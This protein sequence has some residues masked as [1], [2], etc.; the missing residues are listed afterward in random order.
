MNNS[1]GFPLFTMISHAF[2][3]LICD[4][5]VRCWC[6]LR[7]ASG[8]ALPVVESQTQSLVLLED[9]PCL[10]HPCALERPWHG[11]AMVCGVFL[12]LPPL[13]SLDSSTI[14]TIHVVFQLPSIPGIVGILPKTNAFSGIERHGHQPMEPLLSP[15]TAQPFGCAPWQAVGRPL[16]AVLI[17]TVGFR[18]HHEGCR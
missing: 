18:S 5:Y 16:A 1:I 12:V 9:E 8:V 2:I 10:P 11:G 3:D 6:V 14:P 15:T 7:G 13:K 4:A 17:E